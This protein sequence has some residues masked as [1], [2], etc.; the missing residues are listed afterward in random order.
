METIKTE[1]VSAI[2][3]YLTFEII[4]RD[5]PVEA[6]NYMEL[7]CELARKWTKNSENKKKYRDE[8]KQ[9]RTEQIRAWEKRN[10]DKVRGYSRRY[11]KKKKLV[12]NGD[13][14]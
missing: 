11:Y 10:P 6:L 3:N 8:N 9:K 7:I 12:A 14:K 4:E 2:Q 1:D 5:L 13:G